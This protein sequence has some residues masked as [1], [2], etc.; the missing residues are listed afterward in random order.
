[1]I[2]ILTIVAP[3]FALIAIGYGAGRSGYLSQEA[4]KGLS[5]FVFNLAIPSMLFH[6]MATANL[7]ASPPWGLWAAYFGAAALTWALAASATRWLLRRPAADGASIAMSSMFGNVVMLGIPLALGTFGDAA[8]VPIAL[9]VAIHSPL[10]WLLA[11]AHMEVADTEGDVRPLTM[12]THLVQ[13]LARNP[14][15]LALFAGI[16]WRLLGLP[17]PDVVERTLRLLG[18]AG[19]PGA[20]VALGLSL[21]GFR[22]AG[23]LPTLATIN[24]LKLAA[25]PVFA[26]VLAGP[27]FALDRVDAGVVVLFAAMPTGANAFLFATRYQ[28]AANSASGA[29]ALGTVLAAL[30][31]SALVAI[32]AFGP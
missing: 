30:T 8:A 3:V 14:I 7:P 25:M 21:T 6:K 29:V 17:L 2:A 20:L 10:L 13:D 9:L 31:V 26:W 15:I 19:V 1:M 16:A 12:L 4:T 18:E 22:I 23:Q 27:V 24:V 28:R 32:L 11:T 5:Q